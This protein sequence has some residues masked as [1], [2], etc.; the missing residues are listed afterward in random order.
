MKPILKK[1]NKKNQNNAFLC[2]SLIR[3]VGSHVHLLCIKWWTIDF[4]LMWVN[5][6]APFPSGSST[7]T[8]LARCPLCI[9]VLLCLPPCL[10]W[11]ESRLIFLPLWVVGFLPAPCRAASNL[12]LLIIHQLNFSFQPRKVKLVGSPSNEKRLW[13]KIKQM[14]G[15]DWA[16]YSW[17]L[18]FHK[19]KPYFFPTSVYSALVYMGATPFRSGVHI[20][21]QS[22]PRSAGLRPTKPSSRIPRPAVV[23]RRA[24]VVGNM[25]NNSGHGRT[26]C[27]TRGPPRRAG[28]GHRVRWT[29]VFLRRTCLYSRWLQ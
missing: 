18:Q 24:A 14:Q 7:V 17:H 27:N 5:L 12:C 19:C 25:H 8:V 11:L 21:L 13:R 26:H 1:K 15:S 4:F 22:A 6:S 20:M 9:V 10:H 3:T 29:S 28:T 23:R 2:C 16:I